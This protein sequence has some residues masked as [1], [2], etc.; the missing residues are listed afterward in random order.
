MARIRIIV[1]HAVSNDMRIDVQLIATEENPVMPFNTAKT[2]LGMQKEVKS[3]AAPSEDGMTGTGIWAR[4]KRG[5]TLDSGCSVFVL[6]SGWL[7]QFRLEAGAKKGS[8]YVAANKGI[9]VNEGERTIT[10]KTD[11]GQERKITFQVAG[12]NKALASVAGICDAGHIVTFTKTGGN[13]KNMKSGEVTHFQRRGNVYVMDAWVLRDKD[14]AKP[15]SG[16]TRPSVT[17]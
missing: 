5:I 2:G 13:I 15:V 11:E 16:F 3:A 8:T 17:R 9:L 6:P 10:F 7:P 12:V 14:N 4:I 1:E